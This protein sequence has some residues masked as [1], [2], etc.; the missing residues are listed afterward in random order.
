MNE[1]T[2]DRL[3]DAVTTA[4]AATDQASDLA[5]RRRS[6]RTWALVALAA[7]V[8]GVVSFTVGKIWGAQ[9]SKA[10]HAIN[11]LAAANNTKDAQLASASI[12]PAAPPASAII[13]SAHAGGLPGVRV[14]PG[15]AGPAGP[16]GAQGL[17]G[18]RGPR[19]FRGVGLPGSPGVNG[20]NGSNGANGSDGARG[21]KGDTGDTGSTGAQGPAGA[22]GSTGPQGAP[23]SPGPPCGEF[24]PGYTPTPDTAL[25]APSGAVVCAPPPSPSPSPTP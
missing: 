9:Q 10:A 23:A 13:A 25:L 5:L 7:L 6:R 8:L 21:A 20:L 15:P 11:G 4:I 14:I 24:G 2:A 3:H 19:G 12:V 18:P 1:P 22:D 16:T 17:L